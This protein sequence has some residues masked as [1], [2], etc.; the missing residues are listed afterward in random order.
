MPIMTYH[1]NSASAIQAITARVLDTYPDAKAAIAKALADAKAAPVK[2]A[3]VHPSEV[4]AWTAEGWQL[5]D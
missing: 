5:A 3:D 1:P 2:T 4:D